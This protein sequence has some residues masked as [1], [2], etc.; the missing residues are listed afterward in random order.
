MGKSLLTHGVLVWSIYVLYIVHKLG[1]N[2]VSRR[3]NDHRSPR[4][5][6]GSV[7]VPLEISDDS[8]KWEVVAGDDA[9]EGGGCESGSGTT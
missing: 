8:E 7:T 2:D 1:T 5:R 9:D 4:T 3:T 6:T